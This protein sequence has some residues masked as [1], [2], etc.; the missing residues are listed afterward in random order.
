MIPRLGSFKFIFCF[1][2]FIY[3]AILAYLVQVLFELH[4]RLLNLASKKEP[5]TILMLSV[6]IMQQRHGRIE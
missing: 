2:L 6:L 4:G 3:F 5:N 1:F